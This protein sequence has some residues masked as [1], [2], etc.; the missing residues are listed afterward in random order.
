MF[1]SLL[2][3][4][5]SGTGM[6]LRLRTWVVCLGVRIQPTDREL[7]CL[8]GYEHEQCFGSLLSTNRSG[9]GMS[10]RLR[11]WVVCFTDSFNQPTG[12]WNAS[13]V[14]IMGHVLA[15]SFDQAIGNWNASSV[16][17]MNNMFNGT[18]FNQP[19]EN[20][21]YLQSPTWQVCLTGPLSINRFRI[22]MSLR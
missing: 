2:S 1:R 15:S 11:T 21:M 3:T 6:S 17:N 7:E 8:F 12:D 13:S 19:I 10:L 9:T 14:T 4:N 20:W 5:R 16:A 18:P 22:G